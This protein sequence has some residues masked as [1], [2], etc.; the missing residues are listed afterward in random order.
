M[1][2][3]IGIRLCFVLFLVAGA[4]FV[5]NALDSAAP[6]P[7]ALLRALAKATMLFLMIRAWG[8]SEDLRDEFRDVRFSAARPAHELKDIPVMHVVGIRYALLI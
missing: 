2:A 7:V 4:L 1:S 6:S 8:I 5:L 3:Q